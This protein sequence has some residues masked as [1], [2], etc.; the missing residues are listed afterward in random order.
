QKK[1]RMGKIRNIS[2]NTTVTEFILLGLSYP[3]NLK[4]LLF[5]V[6]LIIYILTQLGNLLIL[7]TVWIDPKLHAH[8][9]YILLGMLSLLDMWLSSVIVPRIIL[10]F[11]PASKAI[12]F[13]GCVAQLY[14]FHFLGSTQ[15]FLYTL[16]A[17][18][19]YLAICQPLHY[20]ML[21]NGKLCTIFV[22][23][24]WV[25]GSIHGAI[26]ASLTFRLPYCGPNE[27]DYFFCDIPAVLRLA[28]ADTTINE[29]VTF[30]D[31]GVVAASC[32]LLILLSYA[33]IVYAIL[34]I[35]TAEG[36]RRAFST[37]GS[38]LTVVTVY[39]VPCIFIYLR[40]GS[41]SP[42]DGAVAVFYT[43]VTPLL[44]PIIYTLRNQDVK[45]ALKRITAGPGGTSPIFPEMEKVNSTLLTEFILT[46]IPYPLRL[47]VFLLVFFLLIYIFTQ[48][49]NLLILITVWVDPQLHAR[50]MYIFLGVLSIIDMGISSIIVPRLIMNFTLGIKPIPYCGCA[51]QLYFYHFLGSTQCFL[52]TLMAYD[53][54]LAICRPLHY[55]VLMSVKLSALLVTGAWVAG[56]IHGAIQAILTFRLPY[57]GPNQVNYFFCDIPAVLRLA[58]ADT[59]VNEMVTFVDIGV[60][61][62]SCFSLI[63]LSYIQIIRAI[64]RIQTADGRRRAFS[65]CGAHVTVVTVYYVPCT[66]IYLRP[67]TNSPLDGAA[68]LFPTAITPFLNPL[69]YTLRNQDVKL[70]LK[71]MIRGPGAKNA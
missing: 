63:L 58:C 59:T 31:I 11:T 42:L 12:P 16:M 52:Y 2:L 37:C 49:G 20:P 22:T 45:S 15:C 9:M 26:Q 60:V 41:K 53:R 56:S 4:I 46:G 27:V 36:R 28:C 18:D 34:K 3:P 23:G 44:N 32:F 10:N 68:A 17:Y 57:C 35:H 70:A 69:I 1:D 19:R 39:Y 38:H 67:E 61:V 64:L 30:V 51:A 21:M 24:T 8:P 14:A 43:V 55:P 13:G 40:P 48:L 25:A 62:A 5:L 7:I 29:L 54:Y 66:F 50:P 65:T 33:N 71:R 6:F 47:R